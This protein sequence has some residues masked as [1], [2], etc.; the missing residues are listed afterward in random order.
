MNHYSADESVTLSDAIKR[1]FGAG[2]VLQQADPHFCTRDHQ[3]EFALAVM[4]AISTPQNK[5]VV[6]AGTGTGKTYAY[7]A[8]VLLSGKKTIISTATKGLQDQLFSRDLPQMKEVLNL[9]VHVA[10]LKGRRNYFCIYRA[11]LAQQD[12][13]MLPPGEQK[14]LMR[15]LKWA[16]TTHSGDLA[17]MDGLDERSSVISLVTST[18]ENCLGSDCPHYRACYLTKARREAMS[19]EIVVVNHHLFFADLMVRESGVAELLPTTDVVVFDEAHQLND[20]GLQFLGAIWSTSQTMDFS[21]DMQAAGLT[22]ARG[23]QDWM[24]LS[25]DIEQAVREFRLICKNLPSNTRLSWEGVVPQDV[26]EQQWRDGL[27]KLDECLKQAQT[28]LDLVSASAPDLERLLERC[29]TLRDRLKQFEKPKAAEMVRWIE[30]GMNVKLIES[31]LDIAQAMQE[32]CFQNTQSWIF[33]S[34]TLGADSKLTWFTKQIGLDDAKVMQFESPFDYDKQAAIYVPTNFPKPGGLDH[35]ERVA[36]LAVELISALGGRTFILTTTLRA[37]K[38]VGERLRQ[39]LEERSSKIQVLVQG[40][41]PKRE[42]LEEFRDGAN[43]SVLIGS[44]TFWEG[45]DVA[46]NDLQLVIIDKLP[47]PPPGDPLVKALCERV[48]AEHGSSFNEVSIPAAAVALKQGAGRLIRRESDRGML[49]ICDPRLVKMGYGKRLLAALP[50]MARLNYFRDAV[51]Y[52]SSLNETE[53]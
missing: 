11:D 17:Q 42:L 43:N 35:L 4:Q 51:T 29:V 53:A 40:E 28:A 12:I 23:L 32:S 36:D 14:T 38:V 27:D 16:K 52:L 45:I 7:L 21:H 6:E 8:P 18:R 9:P 47:F 25:F 2:G 49:V 50:P 10:L 41:K 20:A 22:Y 19:A 48:E 1:T 31:P 15:I 33:T 30:A 5:L 39:L 24:Q 46:G 37:L 13:L 34:A 3:I 44:Q 26:N